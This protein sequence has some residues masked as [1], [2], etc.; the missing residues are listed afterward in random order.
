M[1]LTAA[2][3]NQMDLNL[4]QQQICQ[5]SL[6]KN[7]AIR[8][9]QGVWTQTTL[10]KCDAQQPCVTPAC[11]TRQGLFS[12]R[13][14]PGKTLWSKKELDKSGQN[15]E[16]WESTVWIS[17]IIPKVCYSLSAGYCQLSTCLH[18]LQLTTHSSELDR[19]LIL[20]S[21][22]FLQNRWKSYHEWQSM[23]VLS[24]SV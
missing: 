10:H 11:K 13:S 16:V 3:Q 15:G 6:C 22:S 24:M 17:H 12:G 2:L 9:S 4:E 1:W 5:L 14:V 8:L 19:A 21:T 18:K 20:T 7:S 23:M